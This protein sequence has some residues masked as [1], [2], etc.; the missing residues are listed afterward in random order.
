MVQICF[1]VTNDFTL[2]TASGILLGSPCPH[3]SSFF[4]VSSFFPCCF[5]NLHFPFCSVSLSSLSYVVHLKMAG[6]VCKGCISVVSFCRVCTCCTGV[7]MLWF[8][9][10]SVHESMCPAVVISCWGAFWCFCYLGCFFLDSCFCCVVFGGIGVV[11][12]CT[13]HCFLNSA[14]CVSFDEL[15]FASLLVQVY[16]SCS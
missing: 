8:S 14:N 10:V 1:S 7:C 11:V 12:S 13:L 16:S 2:F 6:S 15:F 4:M 9:C 3:S 5:L